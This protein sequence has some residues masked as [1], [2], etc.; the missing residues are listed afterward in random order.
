[1]DTTL[2]HEELNK[3]LTEIDSIIFLAIFIK[4]EGNITDPD[5]LEKYE[6]VIDDYRYNDLSISA[7]YN[8]FYNRACSLVSTVCNERLDE[9]KSCYMVEKKTAVTTSVNFRISDYFYP[10]EGVYLDPTENVV[11]LFIQQKDILESIDQLIDS[12]LYQLENSIQYHLFTD[13]LKTA[14]ELL[15]NNFIRVAGV[16]AGVMLE[17]HLKSVCKTHQVKL[18]KKDTLGN[19]IQHLRNIGLIDAITDRKLQRLSDIRNLCA[20]QKNREPVKAEVEEL[21]LGV[22]QVLVDV[23]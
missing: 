20:H 7:M 13:E 19:F 18:G 8:K 12:R 22:K 15:K 23:N 5:L 4:K 3:L 11:P 6:S 1:M 2:I 14:E 10:K 21:I 17:S 16:I 9:F